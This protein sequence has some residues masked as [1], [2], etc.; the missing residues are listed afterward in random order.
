VAAALIDEFHMAGPIADGLDRA[1]HDDL[2]G[3]ASSDIS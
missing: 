2:I 3:Q 1:G